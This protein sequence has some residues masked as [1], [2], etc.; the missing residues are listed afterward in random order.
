MAEPAPK[1]LI[2]EQDYLQGQLT[3]EIRHEYIGG[4]IY[5]TIGA[6]DRHGPITG[7]LFALRPHLRG[8]G[9]QLLATDM[10]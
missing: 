7:N 8:T 1:R 10:K 5:A 2:S 3:S 9:C 6:S 4:E